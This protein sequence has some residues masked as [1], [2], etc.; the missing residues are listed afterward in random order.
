MKK[1]LISIAVVLSIV[2]SLLTFNIYSSAATSY[3]SPNMAILENILYGDRQFVVDTLIGTNYKTDF[4]TNPHALVNNIGDEN[5]MMDN[6]LSQYRNENDPN[7]KPS[8]KIAVDIMEKVYNGDDYVQH[9]TDWVTS[10]AA[11][12]LSIFS[13]DAQTVMDDLTY[14]VGELQYESILKE[15]LATDY[16][17]SDGTTLSTKEIELENLERLD[18]GLKN[19][20]DFASF[21]KADASANHMNDDTFDDRMDYYNKFLIPYTDSVESVLGSFADIQGTDDAEDLAAFITALA[22]VS[23]MDRFESAN[24]EISSDIVYYAP[25]FFV[26]DDT[27]GIVK[28]ASSSISTISKTLSTYMFINSIGTQKEAV[29]DTLTRMSDNSKNA[30]LNSILNTFANEVGEAGNAK[31][32]GY[33]SLMQYLRN[34]GAVNEFGDWAIDKVSGKVSPYVEKFIC[35]NLDMAWEYSNAGLA[36]T[37]ASTILAKATNVAGISSWCADKTMSFGDTCKKTYELKYLEKIIKVAVDTYNKDVQTYLSNKTEEN[38]ENVLDDLLMI[39][40]L[41]LRGE[42]VAYKMTEG[43]W[44]SPLGRLLANGTLNKDET[45]ISYLNDAYQYRVDAIIGAS[46]MPF[47]SNSLTVNDGERLTIYYN[48]SMGGL[49]GNLTTSNNSMRGIGELEYRISSGIYVNSGGEVL[50]LL[51]GNPNAYIP[52]ITNNGGTVI[53]GGNTNISEYTQ[54]NGV[55]ALGANTSYINSLH[56][57]GG[58]IKSVQRD[59]LSC[60]YLDNSGGTATLE[61]PVYC[62]NLS[63]K[64]NINGSTVYLKGD[65]D[66]GGGVI[67]NLCVSGSSSQNLSGTINAT[68]LVYNNTGTVKQEGTIYVSGTVENVSSKIQNGQNTILKSTG[69]IVGSYYNSSITLDGVTTNNDIEFG[70]KLY[71]T[72]NTTLNNCTINKLFHHSNGTLSLLGDIYACDDVYFSDTVK[73]GVNLFELKG[74]LYPVGNNI[75]LGNLKVCGKIPQ[76]INNRLNLYGFNNENNIELCLNSEIT[77]SGPVRSIKKPINSQNIILTE[78]AYFVDDTY[79]G[80]ITLIGLNGSLPKKLIGTAYISGNVSQSRDTKC[81]S[82]ELLS[83]SF[84]INDSD[85]KISSKL[86]ILGGTLLCEDSSITIPNSINLSKGKIELINTNLTLNGVLNTANGTELIFD[87]NTVLTLFDTNLDSNVNSEGTI[88]LKGDF[89]NNGTINI[90]N[91]IISSSLPTTISGNAIHTENLDINSKNY[92]TVNNKIYFKNSY[93]TNGKI[94][95]EDNIIYSN[96]NTS[97]EDVTYSGLLKI[98]GNLVIDG[99]TINAQKGLYIENG[100]LIIKNGGKLI[101][102]KLTTVNCNI[103]IES[104]GEIEVNGKTNISGT[105]SNS[106]VIDESAKALFNKLSIIHSV[107]D[108]S[109]NGELVWGGDV[110]LTSTTLSGNGTISL[111]GDLNGQSLNINKPQNFKIIGKLPQKISAY[112]ANFE[113]LTIYNP[114]KGGVAFSDMVNCYGIYNSNGSQVSGTVVEK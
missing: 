89:Y 15:V 68:N 3:V 38:A 41:R 30:E 82:I 97:N 43:Q 24:S 21:F 64:G 26:D 81:S 34:A 96:E 54:N 73:Q 13:S 25:T 40:K 27:L 87:E 33:E 85:I 10:F 48:E 92:I 55:T 77:V 9:A 102:T 5:A 91:F 18:K 95:N 99:N 39:Q 79:Y 22:M 88:N 98:N 11:D 51:D 23:Q 90:K 19:L 61:I 108:I 4:S 80:D 83:G 1:R 84:T 72:G 69:T 110:S 16:T 65:S 76:K 17:S 75:S 63:V 94:I 60:K 47:T 109:V 2:A 45:L 103:T 28:S 42:T 31:L 112:G 111:L 62:E 105:S 37:A 113:N 78:S 36:Q 86:N 6:V 20:K 66:G 107:S 35:E 56:L 67:Q 12:L 29:G 46:A 58:T 71:T 57:N 32:M 59:N 44:N 101:T 100:N 52:Y 114:T 53:F 49:Y 93:Q 70:E 74:D 14:S 106:V 8:Y 50:M 104:Q 7:Y